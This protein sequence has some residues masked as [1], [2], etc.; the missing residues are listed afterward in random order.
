[1]DPAQVHRINLVPPDKLPYAPPGGPVYDTGAYAEALDKVLV[2]AGYQELRAEQARR[3]ER[4]DVLQLGIGLAS[5]VEITA[6]D[7]EGG[8][9]ARLVV[10]GDGTAT[11]Y[12]GSSAHS[13]GHHTT[14]AMLVEAELGI[15]MAKVTVIHGNTHLIPMGVGTD[16]TRS[17]QLVG[18]ITELAEEQRSRGITQE[19]PQARR[20]RMLYDANG[21]PLTTTPGDYVAITAAELPRSELPRSE[22][23]PHVTPLGAKGIGEAGTIGA[24]P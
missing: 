11:V 9:T 19:V 13:Q 18:V 23:P 16:A 8:E 17:L 10:D 21:C 22:T 20:E 5:Y 3:R 24:A 12:T 14:W 7:A 2:G 6:A 4:G 1:M 15:Q